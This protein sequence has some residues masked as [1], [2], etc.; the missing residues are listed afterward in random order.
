MAAIASATQWPGVDPRALRQPQAGRFFSFVYRMLLFL[1][2]DHPQKKHVLNTRPMSV[3]S[4]DVRDIGR[5]G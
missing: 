3:L 2:L 4:F 5:A 1:S